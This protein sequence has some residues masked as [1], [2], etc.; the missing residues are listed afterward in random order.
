MKKQ[1]WSVLVPLVAALRA[2]IEDGHGL[3]R[4]SNLNGLEVG[5]IVFA[6]GLIGAEDARLVDVLPGV[7]SSEHVIDL[8]A[9]E[10]HFVFELLLDAEHVGTRLAEEAEVTDSLLCEQDVGACGAE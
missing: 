5:L 7:L 3:V 4:A 8:L 6:G 1:A 10:V 9:F 2:Q